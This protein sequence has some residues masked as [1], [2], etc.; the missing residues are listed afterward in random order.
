MAR[1]SDHSREEL[2]EMAIAA[3][4]NILDAEGMAGLSTRKVAAAIGYT[5]GTLYLVFKNI[6]DLI[7]HVNARTLDSLHGALTEAVGGTDST[8]AAMKKLAHAYIKFATEQ[9][10]RWSL[11]FEH[12]LPKDQDL[13][14]WFEEKVLALF[15]L[16]ERQLS[17]K[18][19]EPT[20]ES[21][22]AARAIWSAV[23]GLCVLSLSEKL[24]VGGEVSID[25]VADS[26]VENYL[27]GLM[28]RT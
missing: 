17:A 20:E 7:L 22:V 4:E 12:R 19:A 23:H 14:P 26:L 11:L 25:V 27:R 2:K 5:V 15:A 9:N 24:A 21:L 16:V 1:R 3:A 18:D 13:P 10:A 6:D 8:E 28:A